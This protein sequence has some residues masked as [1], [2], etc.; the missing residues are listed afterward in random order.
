MRVDFFDY[1]LPKELIAQEPVTPR[2]SS[3]LL[4]VNRESG[5]L[6]HRLFHEIG[7]YLR[8]GDCLTLND[9]RV[10]P[11]RLLGHRTAT[12]GK[13]EGLF[14]HERDGLWELLTQTRGK[15]TVGERIAVADGKLLLELVV[16]TDEGT[17]LARPVD[18]AGASTIELLERVGHIPL[19]HYIRGGEDSPA[20]RERYQTVYAAT[21]GAVAAPTAGLHFTPELLERLSAQGVERQQITLHVGIGTFQPVRVEDTA[22]HQMHS[23]WRRIDERTAQRLRDIRASGHRVVAVGTTTVRALESSCDAAGNL[24]ASEG[25]TSIFLA[26]P[27][28][29][30]VIDALVTNFHLP[31]STLLMLV[32]AFAGPDLMLHAYREAVRLGYRFYSY[33]DAMLIA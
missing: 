32:C 19:P 23:E 27:C 13:W 25:E 20:D 18:A 26:P 30:H 15:P 31:R 11:S 28:Q 24:Q 33:G 5:R 8:A 14:L 16:K 9:T 7:E 2:D 4:V 6:E 3:R 21:P 1:D 10:L 22:E 17:W 29:F 12:G